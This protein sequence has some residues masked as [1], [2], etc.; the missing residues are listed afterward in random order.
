VDGFIG[1][2]E[3]KRQFS[4]LLDRVQ[5]GERL[6]ITRRGKPVVSL[7][8]PGDDLADGPMPS[9][10]GFAALAGALAD[11]DDLD[12]IV[13]EIRAARAKAK[14]RAAPELD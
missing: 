5:G 3:A 10:T 7:V 1:V 8:P 12:E 6:V 2:A 4:A 11:W 9:P 13:G 14:D